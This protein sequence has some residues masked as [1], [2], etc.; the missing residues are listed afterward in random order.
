M[1]S[2]L[3][4]ARAAKRTLPQNSAD[5]PC[6]DARTHARTARVPADNGGKRAPAVNGPLQLN[7]TTASVNE[8]R[9]ADLGKIAEPRWTPQPVRLRHRLAQAR[10]GSKARPDQSTY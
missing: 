3:R 5:I 4:H 10:H 9:D 2:Q 7:Q 6:R 1:A 8:N